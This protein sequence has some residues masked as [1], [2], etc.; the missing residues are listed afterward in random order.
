MWIKEPQPEN[1]LMKQRIVDAVNGQL[2]IKG[3]R[4]VTASADLGVSANTST[5]ERHTLES[6]YNGFPGDWRWRY[7]GASPGYAYIDTY[8]VG[9]LI[10]DLFDR[11]TKQVVWRGSAVDTVSDKAEKNT[12]H[13][14]KAVEK[15]FKDF[16]PHRKDDTN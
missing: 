2:A 14:N 11:S 1:P 5:M 8:E 10:V 3:L 9:T 4:L 7:W 15:M 12:K 16:P 13:L 6:F